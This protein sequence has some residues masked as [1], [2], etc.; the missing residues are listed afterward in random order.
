MG[1]SSSS[2][3]SVE[4]TNNLAIDRSATIG[5]GTGIFDS[6][7]IDPSDEVMIRTIE[8]HRATFEVL[9][10]NSTIQLVELL[11][12][13]KDVLKLAEGQQIR[14]DAF[15]Y[16]QLKTGVEYLQKMNE[17]GKYV[18]DFADRAV[19]QSYNLSS[20]ALQIV[21]DTN[22]DTDMMKILSSTIAAV[23]IAAIIFK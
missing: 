21:A 17:Q 15:G 5:E 1:G 7:I 6:I 9:T 23:A 16:Q 10:K 8:E 20:Q 2:D 3:A 11:D 13:G 12:L 18:I 14:M 4:E 22:S 19:E